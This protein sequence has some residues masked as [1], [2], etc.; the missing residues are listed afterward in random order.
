MDIFVCDLG[1]IFYYKTPDYA[2]SCLYL[3]RR[4][5][6]ASMGITLIILVTTLIMYTSF[7]L[8]E[9]ASSYKT[10]TSQYQ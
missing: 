3:Y 8:G 5:Q 9:H 1:G 6:N 7:K 10:H 2:I 4:L